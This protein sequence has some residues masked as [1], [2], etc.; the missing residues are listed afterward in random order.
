M[1]VPC[2]HCP[3]CLQAKADKRANLIRNTHVPDSTCYFITLTY[4][5]R[6]IPFVFKSDLIR[7]YKLSCHPFYKHI[8]HTVPVYRDAFYTKGRGIQ[9]LHERRSLLDLFPFRPEMTLGILDD[10]SDF[11]H[12]E[13]VPIQS[14]NIHY[15]ALHTEKVSVAYH[16][17]KVLFINRLRKNI[18]LKY[19]SYL[20]I[21]YFY[22]PEYGPTTSRFHI[23]FLLWLPS[24]ISKSEAKKLVIRSWP[25]ADYS[26]LPRKWFQVA[27]D[28]AGYVASYVN[29]SDDVSPFLLSFAPLRTSHS[30]GFGWDNKSF[31]IT[32]VIPRSNVF[33]TSYTKVY[34]DKSQKIKVLDLPL[35]SYVNYRYFPK[36]KGFGRMSYDSLLSLYESIYRIPKLTIP[37]GYR[38]DDTLFQLPCR[39][40]Y[41]NGISLTQDEYKV[42]RSRLHRS[43]ALHRLSGRASIFKE[44]F[45]NIFNYYVRRDFYLYKKSQMVDDPWL[46]F[47]NL[48]DIDTPAHVPKIPV[49]SLPSVLSDTQRLVDRFNSHIKTRK[50]NTLHHV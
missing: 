10:F 32:S 27:K 39:D 31:D 49:N 36:C 22:S 28:A 42:F 17:D 20:P 16:Q 18:F 33:K 2:G 25:Y 43:F 46:E 4:E 9:R 38:G 1:Y 7:A 26:Q 5:N 19:G 50:I 34:C 45:D 48:Q 21:K 40:I 12:N 11:V 3:A 47:Y 8:Q 35:P 14:S 41:N 37:C 44:F 29:C 24:S 15:D 13:L 6:F 30:F 23:H